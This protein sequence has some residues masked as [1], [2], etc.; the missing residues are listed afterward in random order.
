MILKT[1]SILNFKNYNQAELK[2]SVGVN[3]F[4][5]MNGSGKTNLLDAIYYLSMCKSYFNL[6][7]SQNIKDDEDLFV[8]QGQYYNSIQKDLEVFCSFK[9]NGY[10]TMKLNRK[11][12]DKLSDHIGLIPIIII[13]PSDNSLITEGSEERRR[14]IDSIISQYNKQYLE[15]LINYNKI[16]MQRNKLLK[17]AAINNHYDISLFDIYDQQLAEYGNKI[18]KQRT[19]F[20]NELKPIFQNY[21]ESIANTNEKA[22]LSYQSQLTEA[23]FYT[24]LKNNF[25]KDKI[26]EYTSI[27]V[28]KDDLFLTLNKK[29]VK[30]IASQGQQKT[31][32]VSLK[33]AEYDFLEKYSGK[34]PILLLDDIFDKFD[35]Q[36]VKNIINLTIQP[37]FG[38]IFITHTD[39]DHIKNIFNDINIEHKLFNINN[40]TITETN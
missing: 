24:S 7:D 3:C 33:L 37:H 8:I 1:L 38:Q 5:G 26:L 11:E 4:T 13:T 22:D 40:G 32:L 27:G 2:F 16:L 35:S 15:T 25:H 19:N 23:D 10:K 36:R 9:K 17:E 6:S 14:L 28:H 39:I 20:I 21:Y 34:K 30:K 12:Y 29:P 31:Y 18:Y